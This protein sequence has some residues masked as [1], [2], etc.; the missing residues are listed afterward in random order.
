MKWNDDRVNGPAIVIPDTENP[1]NEG[2]IQ[3]GGSIL[4]EMP[5]RIS[6]TDSA[7]NRLLPADHVM[8]A[9]KMPIHPDAQRLTFEIIKE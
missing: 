3:L 5:P 8:E 4:Y 6:S 1:F 2:V 7:R 9:L